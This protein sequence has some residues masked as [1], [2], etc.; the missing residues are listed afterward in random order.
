M[1]KDGLEV[2]RVHC[3]IASIPSFR[4][5][6]LLSSKSIWF[7]A[8]M[9]RAELNDKV[10]LRKILGPLHLS[11]GKHLNSRKILKIFIIC[12]NINRIDQTFQVVSPNFESFKDGKQFLVMCV[13]IQL[14][15][16]EGVKVKSNQMNFIIFV[17]NGEDCSESIVQSISFHDKLSIRNLI[18]EDR[19]GGKCFLERIESIT[20]GGVKLPRNVLPGEVYQ[21][22]DNIRVAKD[23][24][25]VKVCK[26]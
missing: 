3:G 7:D 4:I 18:S 17:H 12:N 21:W 22:N 9:T 11:L 1:S 23:E 2:M 26:I 20:T 19:G 16:S 5:N 10:E 25:I 24:L 14:C 13:V 8:E 6:V 15:Y